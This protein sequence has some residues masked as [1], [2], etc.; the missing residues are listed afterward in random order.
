M[1]DYMKIYKKRIRHLEEEI[2]QQFYK[3]DEQ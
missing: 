3:V 2:A 1:E